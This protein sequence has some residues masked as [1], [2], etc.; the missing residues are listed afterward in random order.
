MGVRPEDRAGVADADL[1]DQCVLVTGSTDGIGREAAI[2][3]GRL[4]ARV[5]VHGRS[6]DKADRVVARIEAAGGTAT[7]YTADFESLD[8]VCDLA[9]LVA[10]DADRIDVLAHNAATYFREGHLTDAGVEATV[11]VN[12]LAPFL[13][14]HRLLDLVPAD[15]RIVTTASRVHRQA[16]LDVGGLEDQTG[17]D[18]FAAYARSKLANVL[19]TSELARRLDERTA[20]CFHPGFVPGSALWR[21]APLYVR[22]PMRLVSLLPN[23][24]TRRGI[25]T[26]AT[27]AAT[28][29]FLAA[30]DAVAAVSGEYFVDC[31]R[32]DPSPTAHDDD[33]ARRLWAWSERAAGLE[34]D[35]RL[36]G[37]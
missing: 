20:N 33:L 22:G 8:A 37:E 34:D 16:D 2:A 9:R 26:P 27:G 13:L 29:V 10:A 21:D 19:F 14:T 25:D 15:G 6:R 5:L 7:A 30:A 17:Y 28:L 18:G 24:L 35:H 23:A 1:S 32:V 36:N 3:F 12:H 31:E 4:G 11:G